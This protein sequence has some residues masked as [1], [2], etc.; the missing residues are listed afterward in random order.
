MNRQKKKTVENLDNSLIRTSNI[1]ISSS[2]WCL[3]EDLK[4]VL[5]EIKI[6]GTDLKK[7][8]KKKLFF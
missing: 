4:A 5:S 3:E 1:K 8:Q 6:S 7:E 2:Y